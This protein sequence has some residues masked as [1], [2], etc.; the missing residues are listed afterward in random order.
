[1]KV[2]REE[3]EDARKPSAIKTLPNRV[4]FTAVKSS[5]ALTIS[6]VLF[7]GKA[8]GRSFNPASVWK[9]RAFRGGFVILTMPG[10]LLLNME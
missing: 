9:R 6:D 5:I 8:F 10:V 4:R 3:H 2:L 7:D 1:M